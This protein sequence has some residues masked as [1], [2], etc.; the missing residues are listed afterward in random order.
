MLV[1][2][3]IAHLRPT[4][5][6]FLSDLQSRK[7]VVRIAIPFSIIEPATVSPN[8]VA[9]LLSLTD[10]GYAACYHHR[11]GSL[12]VCSLPP[13]LRRSWWVLER[14]AVVRWRLAARARTMGRPGVKSRR[15]IHSILRQ[16]VHCKCAV[17]SEAGVLPGRVDQLLPVSRQKSSNFPYLDMAGYSQRSLAFGR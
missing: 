6:F 10:P 14:R 15:N 5:A 1:V 12:G 13:I 9:H 11:R 16:L 3:S 2:P 4:A 17:W 8:P 7:K